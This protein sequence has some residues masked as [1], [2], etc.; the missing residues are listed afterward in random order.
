MSC[1]LVAMDNHDE[2]PEP[3]RHVWYLDYGHQPDERDQWPSGEA[4]ANPGKRVNDD[5][6]SDI[7]LS[8]ALLDVAGGTGV[9]PDPRTSTARNPGATEALGEGPATADLNET[10]LRWGS[11]PAT[12]CCAA[13]QLRQPASRH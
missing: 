6:W 8:Y 1:R 7:V 4:I 10:H 3:T 12:P 2:I 9:P 11:L 13:Q 5:Q